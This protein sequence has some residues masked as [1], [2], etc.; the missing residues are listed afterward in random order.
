[1][2]L[3]VDAFGGHCI[4]DC[5]FTVNIVYLFHHCLISGH[6]FKINISVLLISVLKVNM[7]LCSLKSYAHVIQTLEL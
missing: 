4:L 1:M 5:N 7:P 2:W 6:I 3:H